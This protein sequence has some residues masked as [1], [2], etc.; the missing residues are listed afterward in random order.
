MELHTNSCAQHSFQA[1]F[2]PC[3]CWLFALSSAL[4]GCRGYHAGNQYLYR[5]DIR[6]VHVAAVESDSFRRFTG[7]KLTEAIVRQIAQQTPLTIDDPGLADSFVQARI[8]RDTKRVL[9]QNRFGEPRALEYGWQVE[10]TWVDRA[11]VPLMPRQ[12][13]RIDLD[14]QFIPEA[15]QSMADA[16]QQLAERIAQK[17][18]GQMEM[19]W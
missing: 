7:A 1:L 3:A 19:P 13:I 4:S 5:S 11:G 18:V 9:G 8:L 15:G 16:E 2:V 12:T 14:E 6:T 10:V 17:I